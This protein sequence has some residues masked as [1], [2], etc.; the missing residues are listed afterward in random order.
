MYQ[1]MKGS[2]AYKKL[3]EEYERLEKALSAYVDRGK[4]QRGDPEV[5]HGYVWLFR[6]K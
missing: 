3:N 6:R 4:S 1:E 2:P 5:P